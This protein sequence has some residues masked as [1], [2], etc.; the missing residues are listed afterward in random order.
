MPHIIG[1]RRYARE[2]YPEPKVPGAEGP[3]GPPGPPGP[4]SIFG[5][6]YQRVDSSSQEI[7][8]VN[9]ANDIVFAGASKTFQIEIRKFSGPPPGATSIQDT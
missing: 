8:D 4:T 5:Q 7:E 9:G 2:T 6:D 3:P 1:Q